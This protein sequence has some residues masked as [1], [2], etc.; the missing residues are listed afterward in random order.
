MK[1]CYIDESGT[2]DEPFAVMAGLI[3]D[4]YRMRPTKADWAGALSQLSELTGR[5]IT[6]FH[7]RDFYPGNGVWRGLD[8]VMRA[9]II[10]VLFEWLAERQHHLVYVAVDK[11]AFDTAFDSHPFAPSVGSLWRFMALHVTL[12]LQRHFR[13]TKNNKGNTVLIFDREEMEKTE[14]T[15]LIVEPPSWTDSYYQRN[16]KK[17]RL[18]QIIDVPHFVDSKH[19]GLIQV[20]DLLAF[21]LRRHLEI[22]SGKV[23]ARY[24][25]EG[26]KVSA[27]IERAL[28]RS[29]PKPMTYLQK[30]RCDA[31]DLLVAFAPDKLP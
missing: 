22:E 10:T 3:V 29:I 11:A 4:A 13:N 9:Q 18:E 25:G 16:P 23:P 14:F 7:T 27:W 28:A 17:D 24:E 15:E 19:V 30:G 8:G 31:A 12:A 1:F 26:E 6:E 2:G 21:F 5:A 20:A